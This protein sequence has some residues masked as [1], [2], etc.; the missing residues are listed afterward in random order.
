M[1]ASGPAT[2]FLGRGG[3]AGSGGLG[4]DPAVPNVKFDDCPLPGFGGDGWAPS[5]NV[6][7][8]LVLDQ[9]PGRWL[10]VAGVCSIGIAWLLLLCILTS[11]YGGPL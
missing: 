10:L 9:V 11:S 1:N 2:T 6:P 7:V 3:S 5:R 8:S 4:G